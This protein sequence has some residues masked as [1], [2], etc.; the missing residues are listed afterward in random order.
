MQRPTQALLTPMAKPRWYSIAHTDAHMSA[1]AA[2]PRP[3]AAAA[4]PR[5]AAAA[6]HYGAAHEA[7]AHAA[8]GC[9]CCAGGAGSAAFHAGDGACAA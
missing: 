8:T 5:L 7:S 2:A 3:A 4:A 1:A 9:I 6:L